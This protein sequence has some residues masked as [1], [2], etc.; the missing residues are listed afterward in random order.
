MK[1]SPLPLAPSLLR[2]FSEH[3]IGLFPLY[4]FVGL[5][6]FRL[7]PPTLLPVDVRFVTSVSS[8]TVGSVPVS[9]GVSDSHMVHDT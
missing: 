4:V 9:S 3:T 1:L 7:R 8:T 2:H 5:F 6:L